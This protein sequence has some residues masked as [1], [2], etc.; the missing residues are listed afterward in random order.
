MSPAIVL[1]IFFVLSCGYNIYGVIANDI[2]SSFGMGTADAG[3]F[4]TIYQVGAAISLALSPILIRKLKSGGLLRF[5][6]AAQIAGFLLLF[7][8]PSKT[9]ALFAFVAL[10]IGGFYVDS[11][12]NS[13]I[14][15]NYPQRKQHLI[16]LLHFTYSFGALVCGYLVL[17]F[18]SAEK[19]HLAYAII[20]ALMAVLLVSSV[21]GKRHASSVSCEPEP[22]ESASL[23]M[24]IHDPSFIMYCLVILCYGSSQQI[25][26]SWFP[27]YLENVL[28]AKPV[29]VATASTCF[30]VGIAACRLLGSFILGK[31]IRPLKVTMIGLSVSFASMILAL[32]TS[33][34]PFTFAMIALC[35]FASGSVIPF[36]IVDVNSW[37]P[38]SGRITSVFYILSLTAGRMVF[39]YLVTLLSNLISFRISLMSSSI[40]LLAGAV[41]S[42]LVYK[43]RYADDTQRKSL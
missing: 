26:A 11:G 12:S 28:L 1:V 15:D 43:R 13:Y 2:L 40:L 8:I 4:L 32:L 3:L 29:F 22:S 24:L 37:Y 30:W 23:R 25:C 18:K 27:L 34:I 33:S 41:L 16:P 35:G 17:P 6:M 9:A 42:L 5:G 19:W 10:G 31:G 7:V 39:P 21:S 14:A 36:F 38:G 20:G